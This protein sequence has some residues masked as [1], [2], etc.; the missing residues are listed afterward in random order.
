M[1]ERAYDP[2]SLSSLAFWT[3]PPEQRDERFRVLREDRPVSWQPPA[4][5]ALMPQP[6]GSGFW[7]V[8]RHSDIQRVSKDPATF[9]SGKGIM[10]DNIPDE[11]SE[12]ANSFLSTD[13]PRHTRLR[14]LVSSA[15]TPRQ[16]AK[17]ED[18]I[19][20][21]AR[22]IVDELIDTGDCDFVAQVAKPLPMA[23]IFDMVGLD[24]PDARG[25]AVGSVDGMTAWSDEDIRAGREPVVLLQES[26]MTLVGLGM[27]L[28]AERRTAP[29]EDLISNLI[30]AEVDGERLTDQEICAFFVLLSVAGNDT[31]RNTASHTM[32]ALTE[33]PD[34][35]ALLQE[36]LDGQILTGV[37]EFV[38]WSTPV[39]DFRRTATR[40]CELAGQR[41]SAGDWVVMFYASGNRDER[42][43]TDPHRF[44]ITRSPNPHV[45]FGGGG[46]HF[47]MGA[48]LARTQLRALFTELLR[49]VPDLEVGQ[50]SYYTSNLMSAVKSLPCT[51]N[52][53][54]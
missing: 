30:A 41:I 49:R 36:D 8:V 13:A 37:E 39:M 24:D 10:L 21:R 44:D 18:Q 33:F 27:S 38:R 29:R 1:A 20:H 51:L 22:H 12:A 17:I 26:L 48:H 47:C 11:V 23:T 16:V 25:K 28:I 34:Q 2:V 7:A 19:H 32:R 14:R 42:V 35:R 40:D 54:A 6:E 3:L 9:C 15:F 50:P 4:E 43:F 53:I 52:K 31:T 46:P 45:G 5:G